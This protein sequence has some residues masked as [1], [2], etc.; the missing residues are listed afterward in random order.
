MTKA[1]IALGLLRDAGERGVT[2][3]EFMRAGVGSRYG[4][5]IHDLRKQGA[6]VEGEREREGS[7][8]YWLV[9][10]VD[11]VERAVSPRSAPA[12]DAVLAPLAA[13]TDGS[14]SLFDTT[15]YGSRTTGPYDDEEMQAA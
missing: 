8:R 1:Q 4:A 12:H 15:T 13:S 10:D 7:W 9:K 11:E 2:T 3:A 6:K 14:L 5:R